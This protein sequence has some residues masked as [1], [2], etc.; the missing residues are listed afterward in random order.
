MPTIRAIL[1]ADYRPGHY[2]V[3]EGVIKALG[4]VADVE[5]T[6]IDIRRRRLVPNRLL[7]ALLKRGVN[8]ERLIGLGY[9]LSRKDLGEADLIVSSGG[10][11]L[12]ANIAAADLL[13]ADNIFCGS[14]RHIPPRLFSLVLTSY[15]RLADEPRH[16]IV[17]KPNTMDPDK[18][19]RSGELPRFTSDH[20]PK[21]A[22]C[23]IGGDSG[24]FDFREDEWRALAERLGAISRAYGT[25]WLI[26]T[27]R[28]TG[29]LAGDIFKELAR[30]EDVVQ[31]FVDYRIQGPGT[32]PDILARADVILCTADSSSMVS[33]AVSA[34]QPVIGIMPAIFG[35]KPDE[36]EY[37]EF[38]KA[39]NWC[40]FLDL[41]NLDPDLF[42]ATLSEIEPMSH[43][44]LDVLAEVLQKKLPNLFKDV[45]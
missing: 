20:P 31:Q 45:D 26:S 15:D 27:S 23:L 1:L 22:G 38:L 19:G 4:R 8:S 39:R 18:L 13:G 36:A 16:A 42:M 35:Y 24:F 14:L 11:T 29:D 9:G 41:T 44:H 32:L 3:S 28:R 37:L 6:R 5:C 25:K 30:D 34:R 33:E 43:N 21:L 17:L 40:R 2:H 7:R 10:E 12:V